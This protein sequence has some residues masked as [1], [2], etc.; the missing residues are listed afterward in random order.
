M[1]IASSYKII[2]SA[3]ALHT[4]DSTPHILLR[5]REVFR[6]RKLIFGGFPFLN[7]QLVQLYAKSYSLK[8]RLYLFSHS[9]VI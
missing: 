5:P 4:C 6:T 2:N 8:P 3:I 9:I 7:S 1:L